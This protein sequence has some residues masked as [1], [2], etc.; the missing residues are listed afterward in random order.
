MQPVGGVV[1]LR[2]SFHNDR[3]RKIDEIW[4]KPAEF[5]VKLEV[6]LRI[7]IRLIYL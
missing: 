6:C 4:S 1:G 5:K 3:A 2:R 7:I